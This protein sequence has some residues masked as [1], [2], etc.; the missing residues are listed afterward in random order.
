MVPPD[1]KNW[2]LI[3]PNCFNISKRS[4][5]LTHLKEQQSIY[6]CFVLISNVC[7]AFQSII[8]MTVQQILYPQISKLNRLLK[9]Y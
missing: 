9:A 8:I 5:P 6:F 7:A 1:G 2:Q 4:V 3:F